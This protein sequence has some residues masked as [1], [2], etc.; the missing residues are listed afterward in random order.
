MKKQE[1]LR[2]ARLCLPRIE[3]DDDGEGSDGRCIS[4][5]PTDPSCCTTTNAIHDTSDLEVTTLCS[6]WGGMGHIYRVS[7]PLHH[8][9]NS[10]N[11]TN[12]SSVQQ[13]PAA[14][15]ITFIIK[16]IS[17]RKLQRANLGDQR[18]A[19]SYQ[20]E[21]NFYQH[22][23]PKLIHEYGVSIPQPYLVE[24]NAASCEIVIA[25]SFVE[26]ASV[27]DETTTY[28]HAVLTWL[29]KF[30]ASF[31]G[32][33]RYEE[34]AQYL[35]ETGSYWHLNT[36]LEEH[37]SMP[38]KGW[39]GRLKMAARS[40]D[41]YLK[42][43]PH[44]CMIHGDAKDANIMVVEQPSNNNNPASVVTLC[45]FQYCGKG[46][47][48]RDLAYF[49]CSSMNPVDEGAALEFYLNELTKRLPPDETPPS[50][51][52]LQDLLDLAYCDYYRFMSGWGY[53][54]SGGQDRVKHVL[55]RLDGGKNLGSEDAYEEAIQREYG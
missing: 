32:S 25:M 10:C 45:D 41:S 44:Q 4:T 51:S 27:S 42:R 17:P 12:N 2:I 7:F 38:N 5:T 30:H 33:R 18:K 34:M 29:A 54:G 3:E 35:Q 47:P 43:S 53:W 13:P 37:A 8:R 36:R 16:H 1:I 39:E 50:L 22:V 48:T 11:K 14:T 31:W 55:D 19:A 15:P 26:N 20:V 28:M 46:P 23:A 24:R 21:A 52:E 49:F 6:L 40:I 9:K